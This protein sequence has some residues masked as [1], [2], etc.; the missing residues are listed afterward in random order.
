[1]MNPRKSQLNWRLNRRNRND[2]TKFAFRRI[3]SHGLMFFRDWSDIFTTFLGVQLF[4]WQNRLIDH[5]K[6]VRSKIPKLSIINMGC[7]VGWWSYVPDGWLGTPARR[8]LATVSTNR[9]K[10]DRPRFFF[11]SAHHSCLHGSDGQTTSF[12]VVIAGMV[13]VGPMRVKLRQSFC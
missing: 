1:M 12:L 8:N 9:R 5:H 10:S 6:L 4:L 11:K 3:H 13:G 7:M 2:A